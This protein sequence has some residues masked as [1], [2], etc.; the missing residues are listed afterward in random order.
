MC[1]TMQTTLLHGWHTS[2]RDKFKRRR[3]KPRPT[4]R[5]RRLQPRQ[6]FAGC[7]QRLHQPNTHTLTPGRQDSYNPPSHPIAPSF[8]RTSSASTTTCF[9]SLLYHQDLPPPPF[10]YFS[11]SS[12]QLLIFPTTLKSSP[13]QYASASAFPPVNLQTT[14]FSSFTS[15]STS[16][17][18]PPTPPPPLSMPPPPPSQPLLLPL[19]LHHLLLLHL[20]RL[21]TTAKVLDFCN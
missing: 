11:L 8:F 14:T 12:L 20:S 18:P 17:P 15:F 6:G 16:P 7:A 2:A 9:L 10:I 5:P 1:Y 3:M 13:L 4:D 21:L 19:R